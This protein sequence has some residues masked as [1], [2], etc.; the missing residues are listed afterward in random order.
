MPNTVKVDA[1][2]A[3]QTIDL[4]IVELMEKREEVPVR[5]AE[6]A[7]DITA[8]EEEE[9]QLKETIERATLDQRGRES[10]LEAQKTQRDRYETQLNEVKTNVAYSALLT[11]IQGAKRQIDEL[12]NA[13]MGLMEQQETAGK[14]LEEVDTELAEKR[15]AA[16]DE[17]ALLDA[18]AAEL[19]KDLEMHNARREEA[20]QL[21]DRQ[22]YQVYDRLR[23]ARRFPALVPVRGQA[24][25]RC[26]GHMPPQIVREVLHHDTIH[27]CEACGVLVYGEEGE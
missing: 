4:A 6:V 3:L 27:V 11:E 14:R 18:Q 16:A 9:R 22:L 25:G 23:R 15:A 24:C 7:R 2:L 20:A 10:E 19:D 26:H 12:E 8:L 21:V 5:R 13:I 1:L 17:L